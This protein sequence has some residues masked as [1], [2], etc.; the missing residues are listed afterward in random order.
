MF[1][2]AARERFSG[3]CEHTEERKKPSAWA[4]IRYFV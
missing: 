3:T 2:A 1:I 4:G